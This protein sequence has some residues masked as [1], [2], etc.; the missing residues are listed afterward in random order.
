MEQ[1][2]DQFKWQISPGL[3]DATHLHVESVM[4]ADPHVLIAVTCED[5]LIWSPG[6]Y[7]S[8][9]SN[10]TL[11]LY[12]V[13]HHADKFQGTNK[14]MTLAKPWID[15]KRIRFIALSEHVRK[16]LVDKNGQVST[17]V[18]PPIFEINEKPSGEFEHNAPYFAMQGS[19]DN[20]RRAYGEVFSSLGKIV[21]TWLQGSCPHLWVLGNGSLKTVPENVKDLIHI[22]SGLHYPVYYA[23]LTNAVALFPAFA[24]DEYYRSMASS[25]VAASI[26]AG[27]PLIGSKKLL[28]SY[29]Y[30]DEA[31]IIVKDDKESEIEA[32]FRYFSSPPSIRRRKL[33]SL[34]ALRQKLLIDNRR[35]LESWI[36]TDSAPAR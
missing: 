6:F 24:S 35:L 4:E 11:I 13:V 33:A 2:L 17:G 15:A 21:E 26:I 1:I 14:V 19:I 3:L 22:K 30:L 36:N 7:A 27:S 32:A 10:S 9:L 18:L 34:L 23:T 12:C 8:L 29:T 31:S 28:E 20:S 5:D 25:T 16:Y